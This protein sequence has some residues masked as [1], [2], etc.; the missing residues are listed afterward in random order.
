MA[1]F[2]FRYFPRLVSVPFALAIRKKNG[3][4]EVICPMRTVRETILLPAF[5]TP[6]RATSLLCETFTLPPCLAMVYAGVL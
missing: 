3:V 2:P 4:L 1:Y 6:V 5:F